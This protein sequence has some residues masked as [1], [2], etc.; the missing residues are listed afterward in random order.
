MSWMNVLKLFAELKKTL[1]HISVTPLSFFF[2]SMTKEN[3]CHQTLSFLYSS[4]PFQ[5]NNETPMN[6]MK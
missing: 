5:F 6:L 1:E 2:F 4:V 3:T